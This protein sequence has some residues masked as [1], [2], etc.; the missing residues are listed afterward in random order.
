MAAY[1]RQQRQN[2]IY[3]LWI[4]WNKN[5]WPDETDSAIAVSFVRKRVFV[6]LEKKC[7]NQVAT[8]NGMK[9]KKKMLKAALQKRPS[10]KFLSLT[11]GELVSLTYT[12]QAKY[13]CRSITF[14]KIW[15]IVLTAVIAMLHAMPYHANVNP[16]P[17]PLLNLKL[18]LKIIPYP[19]SNI[20][21]STLFDILCGFQ[22]ALWILAVVFCRK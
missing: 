16:L 12:Y 10:D 20:E 15:T 22:I 5:D 1:L 8:V 7:K 14:A 2:G 6:K 13:P 3:E 18:K 17:M 19:I 4:Y 9:Y 21:D 11:G